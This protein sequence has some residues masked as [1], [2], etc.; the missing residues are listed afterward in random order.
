MACIQ[1]RRDRPIVILTT[2]TA[3]YYRLRCLL[4]VT[5]LGAANSNIDNTNSRLLQTTVSPGSDKPRLRCLLEVTSLGAANSNIGNTNSRLLQTTVSPGSD[6]PRCGR[7]ASKQTDSHS[8]GA[9][10][11]AQLHCL[12]TQVR[13]EAGYV[14]RERPQG[15]SVQYCSA[16]AR[17]SKPEDEEDSHSA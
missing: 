15:E 7:R 12:A 11:A 3:G 5:S 16:S 14:H 2:Q 1:K 6:K 10:H 8:S 13:K 9:Q 17:C 4:E